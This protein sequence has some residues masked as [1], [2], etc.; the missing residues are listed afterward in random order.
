MSKNKFCQD[1]KTIPLKDVDEETRE[2][3]YD[4]Q[5]EFR[6]KIKHRPN[7]SQTVIKIIREWKDKAI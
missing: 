5:N 3:I 1:C 2:I 4:A 6:K 7:I